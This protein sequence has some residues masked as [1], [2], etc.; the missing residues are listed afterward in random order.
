MV[1]QYTQNTL[2][3]PVE[4]SLQTYVGQREFGMCNF[5]PILTLD[6]RW[7]HLKEAQLNIG[8]VFRFVSWNPA[9][10][11]AISIS[12]LYIYKS[13]LDNHIQIK[14]GYLFN[15]YEFIG[16]QV[17]GSISAGAQGVYAV[18]PYNVGLSFEPISTPSLNLKWNAPSHTYVKIGLQ[19]SID[20]A[21]AQTT[22]ARNNTG[23]RFIPRGE[24]LLTISEVGYNHAATVNAHQTWIR[25]GYLYNTTR[26][27]NFVTGGQTSGN[28]GGY[29]LGDH[30]LYRTDTASHGLYA[31]GS[32]EFTAASMNRYSRYYEARL[33]K[34]GPFH[35]RPNDMMTLIGTRTNF[36]PDN[37]GKLL[38]S[39]QTAWHNSSTVTASYS[40]RPKGWITFSGGLT[41]TTGAA[42]TPHV[43][44]ALTVSLQSNAFF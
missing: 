22:V 25:A 39:S 3:K 34:M 21:G 31:G 12:T 16:M 1:S 41:Y 7:F 38:A 17:G 43:P 2:D 33:Y 42:I 11:N 4:N 30:Q 15:S 8:G 19:R 20:P 36:S 9:G 23:F 6:L 24:K 29:L 40:L 13:F 44:N 10:P 14:A 18:L 28:Y 37:V 5:K 35:S 32:F 27:T 26:Y